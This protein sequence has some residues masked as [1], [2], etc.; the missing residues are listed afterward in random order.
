MTLIKV[1]QGFPIPAKASRS[2]PCRKYP[3]KEMEIGDSFF[4]AA[5]D[6][7]CRKLQMLVASGAV[8]AKQRLG[9]VFTVRLVEGGVRAWR[10]E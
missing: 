10:V 6:A 3:W 4:V 2:S 9:R 8:S 7:Q 1:E 5:P